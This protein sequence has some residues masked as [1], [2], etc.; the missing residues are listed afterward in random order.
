MP[1]PVSKVW[2]PTRDGIPAEIPGDAHAASPELG[3]HPGALTLSSAFWPCDTLVHRSWTRQQ[4]RVGISFPETEIV[5]TQ[6]SGQEQSRQDSGAQEPDPAPGEFF[7]TFHEIHSL[8]HLL[9]Q[10]TF[11]KCLL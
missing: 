1:T 10:E 7:H 11:T 8:I 4:L 2:S 3:P 9:I 5:P 6:E